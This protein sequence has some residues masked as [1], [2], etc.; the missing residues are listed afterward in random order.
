MHPKIHEKY[1]FQAFPHPES[2]EFLRPHSYSQL[3][4]RESSKNNPERCEFQANALIDPCKIVTNKKSTLPEFH[5]ICTMHP[6][7]RPFL[8]ALYICSIEYF[9]QDHI[10]SLIKCIQC[11]FLLNINQNTTPL[12]LLGTPI[13][14]FLYFAD[15]L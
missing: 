9:F 14:T 11:P 6:L 10:S 7:S 15:Q 4:T 5:T 3:E 13:N 8:V 1:K 2:H 12:T